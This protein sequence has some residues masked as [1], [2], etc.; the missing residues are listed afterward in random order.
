MDTD[1][2][3]QCLYARLRRLAS[4]IS[5]H[6][7]LKFLASPSTIVQELYFRL[8]KKEWGSEECFIKTSSAAM[9]SLLVDRARSLLC[10]KRGGHLKRQPFELL[11]QTYSGQ[12]KAR[13]I[14]NLHEALD[15]LASSNLPYAERKADVVRLRFFGGYTQAQIAAF[16]STSA[17]T[18]Q[19]DWLIAR[20]WLNRELENE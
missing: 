13:E 5:L 11:N 18:V 10:Q 1:Y 14:L 20:A 12:E 15:S 19:R 7:R 2:L 8:P 6:R 3:F 17:K 16:Q 9:H 4:R